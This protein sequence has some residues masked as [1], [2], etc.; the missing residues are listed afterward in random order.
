MRD[1]LGET[2]AADL[3]AY[4]AEGASVTT[5]HVE[6]AS[7]VALRCVRFTPPTKAP[8]DRALDR[9]LPTLVFVPGWISLL[10]TWRHFL[11]H[12]TAEFPVIYVESREKS[13]SRVE[14][15]VGFAVADLASD[16]VRVLE[17]YGLQEGSFVLAGSSLG[18]TTIVEAL[19]FLPGRPA[20]AALILPNAAFDL[21]LYARLLRFVPHS[22]LPFLKPLAR[23]V[24]F[25]TKINPEDAGQQERFVAAL[26]AADAVKLKESTLGALRYRM[27]VENLRPLPYPSLVIGASKDKQHDQKAVREIAAALGAQYEDLETFTASHSTAAARALV[28]FVRRNVQP[29]PLSLTPGLGKTKI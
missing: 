19:P 9:A 24:M 10:N 23:R 22:L 20:A 13:S 14:G 26:G 7:G 3:R 28:S 27:N 17:H 21:P 5:E 11:P 18:A 8:F 15:R 25:R 1:D 6:V 16:L 2:R 12:V 4:A 29:A